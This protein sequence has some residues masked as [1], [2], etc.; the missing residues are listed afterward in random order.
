MTNV[1]D[2]KKPNDSEPYDNIPICE[3]VV[4]GDGR[5]WVR[6][7]DYVETVDQFNWLV[8]KTSEGLADILRRKHEKNG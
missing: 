2:F 8:T 5:V 7:D 4:Y 6:V 3:V 1:I